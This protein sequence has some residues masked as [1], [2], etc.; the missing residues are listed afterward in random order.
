MKT[1]VV[2][3]RKWHQPQIETFLSAEEVGAKME[4]ADFL[5]A[6]VEHIGSPAM[7]LTKSALQAKVQEASDAVLDELRKATIH[8][9]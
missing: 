2:T 9:V 6:V 3:S 1:K 8:I 5:I 7:L 4:L